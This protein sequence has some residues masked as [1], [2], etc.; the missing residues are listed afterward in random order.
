[1]ALTN[2]TDSSTLIRE[3]LTHPWDWDFFLA[4]RLIE[5]SRP[6]LPRI[7]R[8]RALRQDPIRF[9]QYI[10]LG[11]ATSALEEPHLERQK[12]QK[13]M[14]RFT[15]LTGPNGAL[16]LRFTDFIRNRQRGIY[17]PDIR[18][19][20]GD[21]FSEGGTAAPKDSTLAEFI[22]I[23]HHRTISLFYR[24]W[25]TAQKSADLDRAEDRTFAEWI[26]STFG[27]GLPEMENADAI[28]G[29][30]R[31][32]FAGHLSCQTRHAAGLRG[33]LACYF[34]TAVVV[35]SF[36]GQWIEIP[37]EQCCRIGESRATG[38]LG[39]SCIVGSKLWDR[40][41]KCSLR[42]GPMSLAQFEMFV[43]GGICHARLHAW[44]AFYTRSE[45]YWEASIV[46]R[47]EEVPKTKLGSA[48]RLGYTTWLTSVPPAR[49]ADQFRVR[50][51]GLSA[52]D[53]T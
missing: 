25:A 51:G 18:G 22:D 33:L 7:G 26:A 9:G 23:F 43:P 15:G 1:M 3:V 12:A 42:F 45:L 40:Q 52:A 2:R 50:G 20:R 44:M 21:S 37:A 13:L 19:T 32:A 36:A 46:L 53:N 38:L 6:D 28:P 17:D 31:L 34:D 39:Q 14:V 16:P 29:L 24:A 41:M 5:C 11:F 49:D 48:G 4:L 8:S 35:E 10:S 27:T 30:H 47:R